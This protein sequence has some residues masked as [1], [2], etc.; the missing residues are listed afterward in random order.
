MSIVMTLF[1]ISFSDHVYSDTHHAALP[2]LS[3]LYYQPPQPHLT[4]SRPP[5]TSIS[6]SSTL[7]SIKRMLG[8]GGHNESETTHVTS[9]M[10]M[11]YVPAPPQ[12]M[13]PGVL[14]SDSLMLMSPDYSAVYNPL[15]V[16]TAEGGNLTLDRLNDNNGT[17]DVMQHRNASKCQSTNM[18]ESSFSSS[19]CSSGNS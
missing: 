5:P 2:H 14:S 6:R 15:L 18:A 13:S 3:D 12:F 4:S 19:S 11:H 9:P 8:L 7:N 16:P 17:L 10:F 1:C